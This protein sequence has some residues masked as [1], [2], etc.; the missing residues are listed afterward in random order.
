LQESGALDIICIQ[1][2]GSGNAKRGAGRM[3]EP[4]LSE[5]PNGWVW[6]K[7]EDISEKIEKVNPRIHEKEELIYIDIASIDNKNQKIISPKRY[8]GK[9]APSR[10]RQ[11]I[12]AGDTPL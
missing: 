3:T 8:L 4:E 5:L 12:K 6:T 7:L 10:A 11:L 1:P 2:K 9:D